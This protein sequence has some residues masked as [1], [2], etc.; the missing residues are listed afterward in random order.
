MKQLNCLKIH[1]KANEYYITFD[2]TFLSIS[3]LAPGNCLWIFEAY[4]DNSGSLDEPIHHMGFKGKNINPL[5]SKT[6][7]DLFEFP[8]QQS[9]VNLNNAFEDLIDND[10][11]LFLE[12]SN[13][14]FPKADHK[15]LSDLKIEIKRADAAIGKKLLLYISKKSLVNAQGSVDLNNIDNTVAR[16]I[17]VRADETEYL[18]TYLHPDQYYITV[19]ADLDENFI[20]TS[21]DITSYSTMVD[22]SPE[23]LANIEVNVNITIP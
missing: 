3:A 1:E 13:D 20:P 10:S 15:Y 17:D 19:F 22:V 2:G 9:E 23:T 11:A 5:Y 8:Q 4:K 14:P 16:T 18:S 6:A 21:G 7:V 12:E